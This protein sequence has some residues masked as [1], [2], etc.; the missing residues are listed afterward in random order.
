[1]AD[2][3]SK[4]LFGNVIVVKNNKNTV[5]QKSVVLLLM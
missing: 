2:L 3:I 4:S 5:M 1:M